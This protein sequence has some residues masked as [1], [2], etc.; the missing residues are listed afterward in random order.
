VSREIH[1][2]FQDA[3]H[4]L[5][6][7]TPLPP[8]SI[9]FFPFANVNSTIRLREGHLRVRLSDL[10]EGAPESV[11][12]ALAHI[13][14]AKLYRKPVNR[15]LLGRFRRY[16]HS[17]GVQR[18]AH[19]VRQL[20]GRK[21]VF[22]ARGAVYDLEELFEDLNRRF[23][24]GLLAQP[25]LTWSRDHARSRL[26]HFD[27]AHNTI[28]ISRTF[29]A[30]SIP[31]YAVE[32]IVYHEMLHLKYPVRMRGSRRSVHTAEFRA[33]ERRFPRLEAARRFLRRLAPQCDPD[34]TFV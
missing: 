13:L 6:P 11:L 12:G 25:R 29:D 31:R 10:L 9:E 33:E 7:R 16:V 32:Y 26:G 17:H 4:R 18:K 3:F 30:P 27:P 15:V 1:T 19:L 23:F 28:V 5:C 21:Q 24:G 14:L 22:S 8:L 34:H 20:R 2:I